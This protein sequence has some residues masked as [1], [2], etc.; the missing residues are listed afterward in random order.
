MIKIVSS[1]VIASALALS[2]CATIVDGGPQSISFSSNPDNATVYLDGAAIGKTPV[3]IPVKRKQANQTVRFSKEG[4]KDIEVQ[5]ASTLNGWF[6]G[7]ILTGGLLGS[8]TDG[9]S[10]AAFKYAQNSYMVT[11][12]PE[13]NT[14]VSDATTLNTKQKI[15]NFIVAG[16]SPLVTEL[17]GTHGQYVTSLMQLGNI[18]ENRRSDI[19]K[20]LRALSDAY[21]AIP[22]FAEK[23]S[24]IM[25]AP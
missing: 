10:G 11:L 19:G 12:P 4:Y 14:Q 22:E 23:A 20:K 7:N 6:F 17:H 24:D 2:G 9:L 25:L 1:L 15:I 5:M 18:S 3:T 16:Y 8:T 21:T 13:N